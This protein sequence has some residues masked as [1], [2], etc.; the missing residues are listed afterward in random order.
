LLL[1]FSINPIGA[2]VRP[3]DPPRFREKA[4]GIQNADKCSLSTEQGR[5][6]TLG[7]LTARGDSAPQRGGEA[8]DQEHQ[9]VAEEKRA[10]ALL[11]GE[12]P[13]QVLFVPGFLGIASRAIR[14][15]NRGDIELF[16]CHL[17]NQITIE[18]AM[19]YYYPSRKSPSNPPPPPPPHRHYPRPCLCPCSPPP[20]HRKPPRASFVEEH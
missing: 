11:R 7:G 2:S 12:A 9:S 15:M 5:H 4:S 3:G 10:L 17:C 8:H 18:R 6:K 14:R 20:H 19:S 13:V 16:Y 1:F